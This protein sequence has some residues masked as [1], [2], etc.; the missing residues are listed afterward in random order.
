MYVY[1]S[2]PHVVCLFKADQNTII[3]AMTLPNEENDDSK[4]EVNTVRDSPGEIEKN[5]QLKEKTTSSDVKAD[6][7][8]FRED[9]EVQV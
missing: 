7:L 5:L 3:N 1:L 2:R 4:E 6:Y 9:L 8:E